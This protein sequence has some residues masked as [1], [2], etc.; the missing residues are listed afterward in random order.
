MPSNL[1]EWKHR[2]IHDMLIEQKFTCV[3]IADAAECH[4][5]TVRRMR[6]NLR[7]YGAT[8]A[9]KNAGGRPSSL[10]P[11]MVTALCDHLLEKPDQYLDEMVVFLWDEY[12]TMVDPSTISRVL[13]KI[14]WSNKTIRRRARE[15]SQDLRDFYLHNLSEFNSYHLVY[16]DESGCDKRI[17]FRKRGWSPVGVTPVQVAQFHRDQRYQILPAYTQDGVLLSRIYQGSTDAERFEDFVEELLHWCGRWPEPKSVLIMDN[18]S[19]H[20]T[21]R[22]DQMCSDAGV[23]LIYLPPYSP[24][25]NPIEEFFAELKAFIKR[26]WQVFTDDPERDFH[27]FL[28]WCVTSVGHRA[29]SS[30]GHFSH[31]GVVVEEIP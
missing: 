4:V 14:A 31:S 18:A 1:P 16:V 29:L 21:P 28:E 9:P 6:Q 26:E 27:S 20:R 13:D 19:F 8:K 5:E 17:G 24:D 22:I 11:P 23:K 7:I 2:Q 10:T 30:R 25:F 12:E 3:Q 15:Q